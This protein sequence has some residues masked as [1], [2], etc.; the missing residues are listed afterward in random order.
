MN[1]EI[2][3]FLYKLTENLPIEK[4]NQLVEYIAELNNEMKLL[5]HQHS[6][7][8]IPCMALCSKKPVIIINRSQKNK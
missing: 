1:R 7:C 3:T 4:Q 5:R 6:Q 2:Q 8:C